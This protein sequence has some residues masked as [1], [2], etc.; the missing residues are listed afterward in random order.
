MM[1]GLPAAFVGFGILMIVA[2]GTSDPRLPWAGGGL[3]AAGVV[4]L[5]AAWSFKRRGWTY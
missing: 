5:L 2:G 4:G 3:V 1:F